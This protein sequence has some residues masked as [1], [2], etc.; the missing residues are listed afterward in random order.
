[1]IVKRDS[2][3]FALAGTFFGLLVGWI[4]GSQRAGVPGPAPV[5]QTATT[6]QAPPGGSEPAPQLDTARASALEQQAK[7]DPKNAQ[8]RTELGNLYFDAKRYELAVPWYEAAFKL[9]PRDADISTDLG[10]CYYYLNQPDRALQQLD[11]SLAI[12]PKHVKAL[13]NQGVVRAFG[14]NDL[15]AAAE[16]WRKVVAIAPD[17]QEGKIAKQGLDGIQNG[18][19]GDG[20]P[21]AGGAAGSG[22]SR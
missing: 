3:A 15:A 5:A 1:V 13:F 14:K 22:A 12:D 10:V 9:S 8:L 11:T 18:H 6:E 7:A 2:L 20:S 19:G 16:S 4:L 21:R 17:S